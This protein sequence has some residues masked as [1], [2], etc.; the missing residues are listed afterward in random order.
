VQDRRG[1]EISSTWPIENGLLQL[2]HARVVKIGEKVQCTER[3]RRV[4]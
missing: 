3:I 1:D 2:L 4:C